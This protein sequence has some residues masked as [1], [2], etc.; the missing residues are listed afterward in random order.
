MGILTLG[1]QPDT[2][3]ILEV[4]GEDADAVLEELEALLTKDVIE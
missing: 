1:V 4:D 2:K 3:I